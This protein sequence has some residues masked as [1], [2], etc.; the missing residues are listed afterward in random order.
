[1]E[2]KPELPCENSLINFSMP[3]FLF[4]RWVKISTIN[5]EVFQQALLEELRQLKEIAV[6]DKSSVL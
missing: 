5:A 4:P 1:M 2:T 6:S 3:M